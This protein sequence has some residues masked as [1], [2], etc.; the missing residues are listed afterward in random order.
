M[1]FSCATV[2]VSEGRLL[3]GGNFPT[4]AGGDRS[5]LLFVLQCCRL[6][7][8][9]MSLISPPIC[10]D[11]QAWSNGVIITAR[12]K[13]L[14]PLIHHTK[15]FLTIK[16]TANLITKE[17]N[18]GR[19]N[20]GYLM[21]DTWLKSTTKN[22]FSFQSE[23]LN[24]PYLLQLSSLVKLNRLGNNWPTAAQRRLTLSYS[25]YND[26]TAKIVWSNIVWQN[27]MKSVLIVIPRKLG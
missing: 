25:N 7:N 20:K 26:T 24:D 9:V 23:W 2:P 17:S 19:Y 10:S 21:R 15:S 8:S 4:N 13:F 6:W 14:L 12:W 5:D 18:W 16:A 11:I 3:L 1:W 27:Q 22:F